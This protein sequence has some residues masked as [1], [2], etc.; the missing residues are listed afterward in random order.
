MDSGKMAPPVRADEVRTI[1]IVGIGLLGASLGLCLRR[2]RPALRILGWARREQSI[3]D[4][5]AMGMIDAGS[6]APEEVLPQADVTII[7]VPLRA[8]IEFVTAN[9]ALWRP[10]SVVTDVGSVKEPI[11]RACEPALREH[12]V[13]FVGSHPMAGTERS[14]LANAKA[15]LY[16]GAVVF[17]TESGSVSPAAVQTVCAFWESLTMEPHT[18]SPGPH[19][20]RVARTSHV[21]HLL[22]FAAAQAYLGGEKAELATGGGF[23]DF[24]RIAASSPDMWTQI[25]LYNREHVLAAL[26]EFLAEVESLRHTVTTGEWEALYEYLESARDRRQT[27]HAQWLKRRG[28]PRP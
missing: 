6:T 2:H 9:A 19:D 16:D 10:G 1:A 25:L 14:G 15:D 17:V 22:S 27:W 13:H 28:G 3:R 20:V 12:D 18:M 24:T 5:L 11:V 8:S 23:R 26:D 4:A 7:C 21:L